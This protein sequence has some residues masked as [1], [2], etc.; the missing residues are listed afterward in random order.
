MIMR[1]FEDIFDKE[2]LDISSDNS[3]ETE[4]KNT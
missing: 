4:E 1:V 2:R 3:L